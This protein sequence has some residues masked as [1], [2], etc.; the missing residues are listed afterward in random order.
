[1]TTLILPEG[2][3]F[4]VDDID[5]CSPYV[6]HPGE[7]RR[8]V[9]FVWVT[10]TEHKWIILRERRG[11]CANCLCLPATACPHQPSNSGATAF[12]V[13]YCS[14]WPSRRRLQYQRRMP[15]RIGGMISSRGQNRGVRAAVGRL[16]IC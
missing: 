5:S 1:M 4:G 13:F 6:E 14:G 9:F 15:S 3:A 2:N 10:L 7:N 12:Q 8:N 16:R 11:L